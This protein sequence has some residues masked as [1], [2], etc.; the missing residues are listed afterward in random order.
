LHHSE[1]R[2]LSH[3][4][5]LLLNFSAQ[6]PCLSGLYLFALR[7]QKHS[8]ACMQM[9]FMQTSDTLF[10][11]GFWRLCVC[12]ATERMNFKAARDFMEIRTNFWVER[13]SRFWLF[14]S[15]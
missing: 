13:D 9:E 8:H 2:T 4:S 7:L 3:V 14:A 6:G 5:H 1:T 10:G 11:G 15:G 12:T